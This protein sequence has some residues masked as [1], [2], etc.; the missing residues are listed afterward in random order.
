MIPDKKLYPDLQLI[1]FHWNCVRLET[2]KVVSYMWDTTLVADS[3]PDY[4]AIISDVSMKYP[5]LTK[6]GNKVIK[7]WGFL[8]S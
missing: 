2:K 5:F 8:T 4:I 7:Y 6:P 3:W 1:S